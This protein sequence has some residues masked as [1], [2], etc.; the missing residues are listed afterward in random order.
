MAKIK[1]IDLPKNVKISIEEK[2]KIIGGALNAYL[3]FK[4]DTQG[5]VS[6]RTSFKS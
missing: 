6:G 1:I 2:K 3:I 4:G 5:E